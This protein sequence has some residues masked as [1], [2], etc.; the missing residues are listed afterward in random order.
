MIRTKEYA[1]LL[2]YPAGKSLEGA[3]LERA[4][5]A[6]SWYERHGLPRVLV[7][8][9]AVAITAGAEVEA[10]IARLWRE[11]RV[12]EAYF[13]DRFAAGVVEHLVRSIGASPGPK[14]WAIERHAELMAALGPEAPVEL[15]PSG[16]LKPVHSVVAEITGESTTCS[17]CKY[18]CRFRRT[19]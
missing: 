7:R 11:D 3:V 16:M 4:E 6:S 1:R 12:D 13:L 10:E 17:Q 5:Q 19:A 2:G 15:L 14:G 18:P 9:R 8:D